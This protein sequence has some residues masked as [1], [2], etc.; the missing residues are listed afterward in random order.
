MANDEGN[1]FPDTLSN[2]NIEWVPLT[3]TLV[4][5]PKGKWP[6]VL[7]IFFNKFICNF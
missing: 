2:V 5:Y 4:E 1:I 6:L 3:L 7:Y